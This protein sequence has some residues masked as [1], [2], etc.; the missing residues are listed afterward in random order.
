MR[1]VDTVL[2]MVGPGRPSFTVG[3]GGGELTP[4]LVRGALG[5]LRDQDGASLLY[6]KVRGDVNLSE[7]ERRLFPRWLARAEADGWTV[8]GAQ[9]LGEVIA[10]MLRLALLE[11]LVPSRCPRC[12]GRKTTY[13]RASKTDIACYRC[14][15]RGELPLKESE[16]AAH[17]GIPMPAWKSRWGARYRQLQAWLDELY[18]SAEADL[19]RALR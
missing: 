10:R 19:S 8:T 11:F 9:S 7:M 16:R 5:M 3:A 15:G 18:G 4:E 14:H 6:S 2:A 13:H 17:A 12:G 1:D